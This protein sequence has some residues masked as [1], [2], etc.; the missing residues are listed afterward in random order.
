MWTGSPQAVPSPSMTTR[1]MKGQ[2]WSR[3]LLPLTRTVC[4]GVAGA[5]LELGHAVDLGR[6]HGAV[7]RRLRVKVDTIQA[8]LNVQAGA[9]LP[10]VPGRS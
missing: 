4:D 6:G 7:G 9:A 1:H 3:V 2:R 5:R 10:S 8:L